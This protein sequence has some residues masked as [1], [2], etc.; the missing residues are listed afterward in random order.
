MVLNLRLARDGGHL[1]EVNQPDREQGEGREKCTAH[2]AFTH[3]TEGETEAERR[4]AIC[5]WSHCKEMVEQDL[6]PGLAGSKAGVHP[7]L[8]HCESALSIPSCL[9][10][11]QEEAGR[12]WVLYSPGQFIA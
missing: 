4:L 10:L 3:L 2:R 11:R 12:T 1:N 9:V 6:N 5:P 7:T 8:C